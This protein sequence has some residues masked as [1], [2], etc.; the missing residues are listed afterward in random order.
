[1]TN[2]IPL[3][4]PLLLP[5]HTVNCVQT[6]KVLTFKGWY[7]NATVFDTAK[8]PLAKPAEGLMKDVQFPFDIQLHDTHVMVGVEYQDRCPAWVRIDLSYFS[9]L[10]PTIA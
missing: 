8:H 6:L 4:C 10:L 3:G 1:V 5:V 2:G 9:S 7:G